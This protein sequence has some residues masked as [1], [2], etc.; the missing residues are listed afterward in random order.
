MQALVVDDSRAIRLL[1]SRMLTDLGLSVEE[2]SNGL[3]ALAHLDA[4]LAPS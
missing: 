2:A 3:E 1:L 4:G